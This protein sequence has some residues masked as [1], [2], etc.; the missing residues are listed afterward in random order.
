MMIKL[1]LVYVTFFDA[2]ITT[3]TS[4]HCAARRV[5]AIAAAI[6]ATATMSG[7]GCY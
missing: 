6:I 3:A 7:L 1:L 4:L 5:V 2:T